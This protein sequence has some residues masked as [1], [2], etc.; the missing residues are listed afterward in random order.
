MLRAMSFSF[1]TFRET[2]YRIVRSIPHGRVMTYGQVS[3]LCGFPRRAR[4]VGH[5]L[6]VAPPDVPCQRVVNRLGSLA[7]CY[8]GG[9]LGHKQDIEREGIAVAEDFTI[10]IE[11][12]KWWPG[13]ELL[14]DLELS[15]EMRLRIAEKLVDVKESERITRNRPVHRS[16]RS[17]HLT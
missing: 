1:P 2:V 14:S 16:A 17:R 3:L 8:P 10:D 13:E 4:L 5:A 12:H 15:P 6:H 7:A 11:K 9:Q